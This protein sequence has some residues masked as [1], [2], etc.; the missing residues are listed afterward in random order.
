VFVALIAQ[1]GAS[2]SQTPGGV[3]KGIVVEG[4]QRIEASTI[5]SYMVVQP[6]DVYDPED[7]DLTLKTLFAT[8]LFADVVLFQRGPNLVVRVV[9]NPIIN[10]VVF[11]HNK[12]L[13]DDKLEEEVQLKPRIVYTRAKVQVDVQKIIEL[14]RRSGRFAKR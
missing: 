12:A 7:I 8:G 11:E 6:G 13:D 10:R 14:Y 3:I 2:Y 5:R 4:N 1:S 9:E